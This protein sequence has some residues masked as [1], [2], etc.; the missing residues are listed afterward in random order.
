MRFA[1]IFLAALT[2]GTSLFAFDATAKIE[3]YYDL[4]HECR[5]GE[6]AKGA[7]LSSEQSAASC[8]ELAVVGK[9]LTK[10]GYCFDNSEQ[11]WA[12]CEPVS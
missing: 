1:A 7:A 12:L 4:R 3:T 9:E 2:L 8:R 6:D 5:V 11:E 10:A